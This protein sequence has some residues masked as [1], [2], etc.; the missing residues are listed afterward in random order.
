MKTYKETDMY[1]PIRNLLTR[2]GFTVR[3][4][5]KGCDIVAINGDT[6]WAV[7]MKLSANITL[8]YQAMARQMATD[9]VFVA[10]PR[11]KNTKSGT[12]LKFKKLI[13]K[14]QLGLITVA[15]DSPLRH[16]EVIIFPIGKDDKSNKKAAAL[17]REVL[18]RTIDTMGGTTKTQIN[19]AYRERCVRIAC[20]LKAKITLSP[21]ELVKMGCEKD[22]GN[23]LRFNNYGWFNR[24]SKGVYE[25][26]NLGIAYL[27]ANAQ[28]ELVK[29]YTDSLA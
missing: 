1:E 15:L 2:Q 7:E 29:F 24:V 10:I 11:P 21:K 8:I 14:L 22:A 23:I 26:S 16:A 19:T 27:N 3:G 20:L 28:D 5:V 25:L 4:E 9:W 18:G 13:K 12:Y 6:M 17:K